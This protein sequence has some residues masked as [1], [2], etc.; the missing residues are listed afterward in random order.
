MVSAITGILNHHAISNGDVKVPTSDFPSEFNSE[1]VTYPE[2]TPIKSF[3]DDEM[4][5]LLELLH[6]EHDDYLLYVDLQMI[7]SLLVVTP[8]SI[9]IQYLLCCFI[10][11]EERMLQTQIACHT[12]ICLPQPRNLR[13]GQ[14]ETQD[15]PKEL[16][17][18]YTNFLTVWL[19]IQ[20]Y[21]FIIAQ[22]TIPTLY[23]Q[24]P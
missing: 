2:I 23:H 17:L 9:F 5:H 24:V 7:Q 15:M 4:N 6:S 13:N 22:V 3:D 19:Y 1:S 18:F 14:M 10:N 8:T 21:R 16:G 12:F 20:L 11:T